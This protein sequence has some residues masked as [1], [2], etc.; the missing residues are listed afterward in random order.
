MVSQSHLEHRKPPTYLLDDQKCQKCSSVKVSEVS[1]GG[2]VRVKETHRRSM[3]SLNTSL[4]LLL[5][6]SLLAFRYA[7]D[8]CILLLYP[9]NLLNFPRS[10]NLYCL[11][12]GFLCMRLCQLQI[13]MV[14]LLSFLSG[15]LLF[16]F[17]N[18]SGQN[19]QYDVEQ[20][21]ASVLYLFLI[22]GKKVSVFHY[23]V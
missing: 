22:L 21:Q 11:L 4:I 19:L 23:Q 2:S 9:A 20:K 5:D 17:L 8:F 6:H 10:N 18:C 14:L 15:C 1:E 3:I 13:K 7:I 12:Q 16:L